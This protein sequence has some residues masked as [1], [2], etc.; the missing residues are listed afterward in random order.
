[1]EVLPLHAVVV[2]VLARLSAILQFWQE[3]TIGD[4]NIN[5][6]HGTWNVHHGDDDDDDDD[7]EED[8]D[9]EEEEEEEEKEEKEE[10]EE[11]DEEQQRIEWHKKKRF[12]I[13]RLKTNMAPKGFRKEN[14]E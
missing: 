7:E 1:M 3:G 6:P 10:E 9:K 8:K 12:I 11:E 13:A 14:S 4:E 5:Q 2:V